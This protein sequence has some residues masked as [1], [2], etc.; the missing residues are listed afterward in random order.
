MLS[1]DGK[2]L[3]LFEEEAPAFLLAWMRDVMSSSRVPDYL[4]VLVNVIKYN[5]AYVDEEVMAGLVL[6]VINILL[7]KGTLKI[8]YKLCRIS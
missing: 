3:E 5:A 2:D 4:Q 7:V 1:Q 6:W 8:C